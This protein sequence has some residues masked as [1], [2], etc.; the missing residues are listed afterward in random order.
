MSKE[1]P[2]VHWDDGK[3][4]HFSDERTTSWCIESP[5][6]AQVMTNADRIRSMSDEELIQMLNRVVVCHSLKKVGYCHKCPLFGAHPCDTEGLE[7]WL[8][9]PAE[10]DTE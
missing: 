3:C 6:E 10:E 5:C 8:K 7:D 4:K 1:Y 9:Q 2:C